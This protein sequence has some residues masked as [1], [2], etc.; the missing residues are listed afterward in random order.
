MKQSKHNILITLILAIFILVTGVY[1]SSLI[2]E[3]N[4]GKAN[5]QD[6]I[7]YIVRNVSDALQNNSNNR[8]RF[9][10]TVLDSIKSTQSVTALTVKEKNKLIFSFPS[11]AAKAYSVPFTITK[12]TVIYDSSNTPY[13][14]TITL[15][16]LSSDSVYKKGLIALGCIVFGI[17]ICLFYLSSAA[18]RNVTSDIDVVP[19][20]EIEKTYTKKFNEQQ[21]KLNKQNDDDFNKID[22]TLPVTAAKTKAPEFIPNRTFAASERTV[23]E[24]KADTPEPVEELTGSSSITIPAYEKPAESNEPAADSNEVQNI[25]SPM[26]SFRWESKF[27]ERL[28]TLVKNAEGDQMELSL[29][30]VRVPFINWNNT[31]INA[32]KALVRET[33]HNDENIFSYK[34]DGFAAIMPEMNIDQSIALANKLHVAMTSILAK[35]GMDLSSGIGISSVSSRIVS[36]ERFIKE[37]DQALL[38]ALGDKTSPV[39]AFR[40]NAQKYREYILKNKL[41]Y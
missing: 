31:H 39:V 8:N 38:H 7:S 9:V 35:A 20:T 3:Y 24:E 17:M 2:S 33:F 6:Q 22:K 14:L 12:T 41:K 4:N 27:E 15:C 25:Y 40:V 26:T 30:L 34:E 16:L 29:F 37:A 1:F 10:N 21:I 13:D 5:S 28:T 11:D 19:E 36:S 18:Y 32:L 23:I